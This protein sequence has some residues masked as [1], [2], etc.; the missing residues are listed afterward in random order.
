MTRFFRTRGAVLVAALF[1]L[2]A[3]SA[4]EEDSAPPTD[5]SPG[6]VGVVVNATGVN[7]DNQFT[8]Q[9]NGGE[10]QSYV[11]GTPFEREMPASVYTVRISDIASNCTLQGTNDVRVVVYAGQRAVVT[12]SVICQAMA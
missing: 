1:V 10:A 11:S 2:G 8:L 6:R 5:S 4:C 12:F 9:F 7:V 3:S